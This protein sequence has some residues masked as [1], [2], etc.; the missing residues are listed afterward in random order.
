MR[1]YMNQIKILLVAS[2]LPR[3]CVVRRITITQGVLVDSLEDLVDF[4]ESIEH[5]H[6]LSSPSE[7]GKGSQIGENLESEGEHNSFDNGGEQFCNNMAGDQ[8]A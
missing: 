5:P 3:R 4:V 6:L 8:L 2:I 7:E 1:A